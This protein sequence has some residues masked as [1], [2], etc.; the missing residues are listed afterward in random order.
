MKLALVGTSNAVL[1]GGYAAALA[2]HPAISHFT[3]AAFGKS[4]PIVASIF[5]QD[6]EQAD[7]DI[8]II[9]LTVNAAVMLGGSTNPRFVA[10][11]T[12]ANVEIALSEIIELCLRTNKLPYFLVWPCLQVAGRPNA[13]IF[14]IIESVIAKYKV[15]WFDGYGFLRRLATHGPGIA[16]ERLFLDPSHLLPRLAFRIGEELPRL[17]R[18]A[19]AAAG[20]KGDILSLP[21]RT[22]IVPL[23]A[24]QG[25]GQGRSVTRTTAL[26]SRDFLQ[27]SEQDEVIPSVHPDACIVGLCFDASR[28]HGVLTIRGSTA[29]S[30]LLD[31]VAWNEDSQSSARLFAMPIRQPVANLR[32]T[33]RLSLRSGRDD[34][35]DPPPRTW[36]AEVA[37]RPRQ[38]MLYGIVVRYPVTPVSLHTPFAV[39]FETSRLID[40]AT[41]AEIL[42]RLDA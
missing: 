36:P 10:S 11:D 13:P 12:P 19:Q 23:A 17:L 21:L 40:D 8:V 24:S 32:G 2:R 1:R 37:A 42:G 35:Q 22:E 3:R 26:A 28:S 7:L 39:A 14:R 9:E 38:A 6:I 15:A 27:M 4:S 33:F 31:S 30:Y 18:T 20:R 34:I 5:S 29:T 41:I 25:P 16:T